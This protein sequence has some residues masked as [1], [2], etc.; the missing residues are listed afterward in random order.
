MNRATVVTA[1]L[2][3]G[4]I[5]AA[6]TVAPALAAPA[7][8]AAHTPAHTA[9]H[10]RAIARAVPGKIARQALQV[11][12][13]QV[14]SITSQVD[15]G[16]YLTVVQCQGPAVPPPIK[17]G[18]PGTPLTA[19]G[20]G[21]SSAMLAALQQPSQYNTVYT[22]SVVVKEKVPAP[23]KP[24]PAPK[25]APKP[26]SSTG[27]SSGSASASRECTLP[28]GSTLPGGRSLSGHGRCTK[29]VT[30]NTG[31]GGMAPQVRLHQPM[32]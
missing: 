6:A 9:V 4:A 22:C 29:P 1:A 27:W 10:A 7:P 32:D 16:K 2:A 18:Q 30:L 17:L 23:P 28:G 14:T 21:P 15:G 5:A 26:G 8:A 19:S 31:F 13:A 12:A 11:A 20:A 24:K 25:P 3:L